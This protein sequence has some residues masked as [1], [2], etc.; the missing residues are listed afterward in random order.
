[1][2]HT[3]D[4]ELD[5]L[6]IFYRAEKNSRLYQRLV[7]DLQIAQDVQAYQSSSKLASQFQIVATARAGHKLEELKNVIQ[8]EI[9]KIKNTP[10]QRE[11]C[12]EL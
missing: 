1:M 5:V 8:E 6:E 10:P 3:G 7:Y 4:A 2:V 12:R 9:D 11:S